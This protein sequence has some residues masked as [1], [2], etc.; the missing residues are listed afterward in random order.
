MIG[1]LLC[2]ADGNL[3]PS[4]EPAFLASAGVT[5]RFLAA[6]GLPQRFSA[7]ELRV[8]TTGKN[9][10]TTAIDLAVAGGIRL[11]PSL[12]QRHPDSATAASERILTT[13]ELERWIREERT[14]VTRHLGRVLRPDPRVLEPLHRLSGRFQLAA[15]SSSASARLAG[16]FVATGLAELFPEERRF[17]A[18]DSL[19]VPRSKPDPAIYAFAG[20]ALGVGPGDAVAIEDSVPG[21]LSA[22]AA[23]LPTLGNLLFVPPGER[24]RRA[25]ELFEAG[26]AGVV[27]S[28]DELETLLAGEEVVT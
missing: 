16:C 3:F 21:A 27:E 4:E 8:A 20:T 23:G 15:V 26:V 9:F 12:A 17:S 24:H 2:D 19:P 11:D 7:E 28:W 25:R 6:L 14:V 10:R 13:E 22:V 5:N 1:T 18:E